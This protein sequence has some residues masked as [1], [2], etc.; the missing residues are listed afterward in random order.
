MFIQGG[1]PLKNNG[2]LQ[3]IGAM[4]ETEPTINET[5]STSIKYIFDNLFS[6]NFVYGYI[7]KFC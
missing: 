3:V 4:H 1:I 7:H 5:A 2:Q 6:A